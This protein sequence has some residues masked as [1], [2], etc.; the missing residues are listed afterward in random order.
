MFAGGVKSVKVRSAPNGVTVAGG[1]AKGRLAVAVV[2]PREGKASG[3]VV[4]RR[5]VSD[6]TTLLG[7]YHAERSQ[8]VNP[9]QSSGFPDIDARVIEMIAAVGHFP[10]LPPWMSSRVPLTLTMIGGAYVVS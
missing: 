4:L 6:S 2:R 8:Q 5:A 7:F 1:V 3:K 9:S 10:S